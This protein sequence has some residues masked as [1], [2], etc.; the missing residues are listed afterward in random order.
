MASFRFRSN[1]WQ[2]RVR[3][4]G[5]PALTKSFNQRVYA[6]RWARSV[7]ADF[8]RGAYLDQR[9]NMRLAVRDLL[10]RYVT[11]KFNLHLM[12]ARQE[13]DGFRAKS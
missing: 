10:A 1:R 6:E 4:Q 13:C 3:S 2:A 8:D 11:H 7:E 9:E 5:H 12:S